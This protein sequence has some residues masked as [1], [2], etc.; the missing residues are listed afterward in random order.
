MLA[1]IDLKPQARIA[2]PFTLDPR[3]V[4]GWTTKGHPEYWGYAWYRI[5]VP[6][7]F[8]PGE[9]LAL[10]TYGWVDDGYQLFDNGELLGSWGRFR[11][12]GKPPVVYFTRRRRLTPVVEAALA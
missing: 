1:T 9:K 12:P 6:V 8:V 11:S 5:R 10:L 7:T 2:D 3:Y 4:R